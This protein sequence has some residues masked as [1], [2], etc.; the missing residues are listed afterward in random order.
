M[1][2]LIFGLTILQVNDQLLVPFNVVHAIM[3]QLTDNGSISHRHVRL[4]N[5][6]LLEQALLLQPDRHP[7]A[8]HGNMSQHLLHLLLKQLLQILLLGQGL[9]HVLLLVDVRIFVLHVGGVQSSEMILDLFKDFLVLFVELLLQD[10]GPDLQVELL[11]LEA[12]V[13]DAELRVGLAFL[14]FAV[15][16]VECCSRSH[17]WLGVGDVGVGTPGLF[18]HRL[19][20]LVNLDFEV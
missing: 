7:L 19:S 11:D 17:L 14:F 12:L 16:G 9:L 10:V 18:K 4:P 3:Q 1:L 13:D 5:A 20:L 8:P 6:H 2:I 15:A